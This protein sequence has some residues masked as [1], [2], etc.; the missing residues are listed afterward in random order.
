[1]AMSNQNPAVENP[2]VLQ[3]MVIGA[4]DLERRINSLRRDLR[5]LKRFVTEGRLPSPES[6]SSMGEDRTVCSSH[7]EEAMQAIKRADHSV[8]E[9]DQLV[10]FISR[11]LGEGWKDEAQSSSRAQIGS[12]GPPNSS[13]RMVVEGAVQD[14]DY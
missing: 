11:I 13:G 2:P 6:Q 9:C 3:E 8:I 7:Q 12:A 4:E 14:R 5:S 1:M 10:S